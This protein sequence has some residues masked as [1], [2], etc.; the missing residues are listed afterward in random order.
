MFL[1]CYYRMQITGHICH[2]LSFQKH[3]LIICSS[4]R[5]ERA[6][7]DIVYLILFLRNCNSMHLHFIL[8]HGNI[9]DSLTD[10]LLSKDE[11][12]ENIISASEQSERASEFFAFISIKTP[13]SFK[14]SSI[15]TPISFSV[16]LLHLCIQCILLITWHYKRL[17]NYR[18]NTYIE[19]N[20]S[21]RA[22]KA[23]EENFCISAFQ[24]CYVC[25]VRGEN[26]GVF[27]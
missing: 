11:Y 9:N 5:S 18:K 21:M 26:F 15:K 4:E 13:I 17:T 27:R 25:P 10:K 3:S 16:T 7:R 1:L 6:L 19:I 2:A 24:T 22:R 8:P 14:V 12:R 20:Y 23:T